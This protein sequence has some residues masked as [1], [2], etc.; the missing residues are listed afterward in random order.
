M[1]QLRRSSSPARSGPPQFL[2]GILALAALTSGVNASASSRGPIEIAAHGGLFVGGRPVSIQ[3]QRPRPK[4]GADPGR[5]PALD[6]KGDYVVGA[7][8]VE[9]T[10]LARPSGHPIIMFPGGGLS[11][12][13][14]QDTPDG[15]PGWETYF[16]RH[17]YSVNLVDIDRTGR[18]PWRAFPEI[19][20][21]EP[22]FRSHSFLWET[23]R[24]GPP[25][26]FAGRRAY[27]DSQFPHGAFETLA[28]QV[29]P[30]FRPAAEEQAGVYDAVIRRFCPCILLL[31][32]AAG[33]PGLAAALRAPEVVRAVVAIEPSAVPR[34][35]FVS[36]AIPHIFIW[37]DHLG[38]QDSAPTWSAA[39]QASRTYA[40]RLRSAGARVDWIDLPARGIRGNS[41]L[42]MM[43]R[44]S[45]E[46]AALI[47]QA[48]RKATSEPRERRGK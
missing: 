15:R 5:S 30:R 16:L 29:A 44:N 22:S 1:V 34:P 42:L 46:I 18:S 40:Q 28:G 23:F 36:A 48:L 26:S 39:Y 3:G 13:S 37:G 11:G 9:Y 35:A 6:L 27:R 45:D 31:H 14:F 7:T 8:Y 33:G 41:H 47:D 43:D 25:G 17:G 24:I 12:A 21:E 38:P 10:T 20:P 32:S 19:E 2:L 4:V